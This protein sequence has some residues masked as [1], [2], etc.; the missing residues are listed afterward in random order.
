[1]PRVSIIMNV[2]NGDATLRDA[3]ASVLAQTV[4]DWEIILWDDCSSDG[5]VSIAE[6]LCD[7]RIR[8]YRATA[9]TSLGRARVRAIE[10]CRGEWLAFLDQDDVWM[11][12]KLQRQLALAENDPAVGILYGRAV[13]FGPGIRERDY[14]HRH[15]FQPLP[16]GNIFRALFTDACYICM[17]SAML[18]HSALDEIGPIAPEIDCIADYYLFVA[19]AHRYQARAVEDV[20]CRYRVHSGSM[21]FRK[22]STIQKEILWLINRWSAAL[23]PVL[24]ERRR[25]VH[26]TVLA[27]QEMSRPFTLPA[28]VVRLATHGC[29]SYLLSRPFVRLFRNVRRRV[30]RPYYLTTVT[31]SKLTT[32]VP[33]PS[34]SVAAIAIAADGARPETRSGKVLGTYITAC[35]FTGAQELIQNLVDRRAAAYVSPATAYALTLALEDPKYQRVLD[36]ARYT[37]ADGMPIVWM[38]RWIG[39]PTERVHHDDLFLAC[40]ERF[41]EWRHFL[42]GGRIGQPEHVAQVLRQR[43][44]G[45]NI[46]GTHATPQRPVA[47]SDTQ[48]I[49][50]EIRASA[51][52]IVWVGMGTP[53]QDYWMSGAVLRAGL[54]MVGVGS[55]FD[56]LSGKTKA[57]PEWM[58]RNGLQWVFRFW[59]EPRRLAS[60]YLYYN[61]RF[62]IACSRQLIERAFYR[63]TARLRRAPAGHRG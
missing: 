7:P 50:E 19:V 6:S 63:Y 26:N 48:C 53:A 38:L 2:Y 16:Q 46:V 47:E 27:V 18:R 30:R 56:L 22:A 3:L 37:T 20:V 57:A 32:T 52:D 4:D 36:G 55:V 58:K 10:Q 1:M 35:T 34:P 49:L 11:P 28:G 39:A 40:C 62:L 15:E 17:S 60:R 33:T 21:S 61:S 31:A 44:P 5:S 51:P 54:P 45:I 14:D 13:L 41:R 29:M 9:K 43:F 25:Q 12:D 42:V 59:Q 23:D 8:I 24:L